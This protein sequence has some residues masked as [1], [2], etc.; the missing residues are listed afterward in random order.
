MITLQPAE[1]KRV[2]SKLGGRGSAL[3]L[4]PIIWQMYHLT[5]SIYVGESESLESET[6][7]VHLIGNLSLNSFPVFRVIGP[8]SAV[9]K[10]Q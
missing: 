9:T 8:Y 5:L 1:I 3:P 7:F 2:T 6:I 4:R 10:T